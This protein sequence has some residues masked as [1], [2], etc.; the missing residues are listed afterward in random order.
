MATKKLG[1]H[2][3]IISAGQYCFNPFRD[4]IYGQQDV[5]VITGGVRHY[6]AD[7]RQQN[8]LQVIKRDPVTYS[9][10]AHLLRSD[11]HHLHRNEN[12]LL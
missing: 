7:E 10:V 1:H 9:V 2:T 12:H 3:S 4:V 8:M 5:Q 11:E 6:E